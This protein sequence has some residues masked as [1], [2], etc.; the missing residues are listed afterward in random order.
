MI[1]VRTQK[2]YD[3]DVVLGKMV[4]Q[5]P[6]QEKYRGYSLFTGRERGG[7]CGHRHGEKQGDARLLPER[8]CEEAWQL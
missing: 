7:L 5:E 6:R 3:H 8:A 4:G 1:V 2:A